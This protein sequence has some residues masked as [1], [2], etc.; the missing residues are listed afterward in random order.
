MIRHLYILWLQG[1][2]KAPDIIQL[3]VRSWQIH[4]PTWTIHL[5][6]WSNLSEYVNLN[7]L[8]PN[9]SS[10][11]E[12][13]SI[14]FT[15]LSDLIRLGILTKFGGLWVDATVFCTKPLDS[16]ILSYIDNGFFA[17]EQD[18][19]SELMIGSWFLYAEPHNYLIN[20]WLESVVKYISNTSQIGLPRIKLTHDEWRAR[21]DTVH[22]FWMHYIFKDLYDADDRFKQIW[23]SV[24]SLKPH[25][26]TKEVHDIPNAL[27]TP[28]NDDIKSRIDSRSEHVYKLWSPNRVKYRYSNQNVLSYLITSIPHHTYVLYAY[29]ETEISKD[30]LEY[31][32]SNIDLTRENTTYCVISNGEISLS[33]SLPP[34]IKLIQR[35]NTGYDFGAWGAALNHYDLPNILKPDDRVIMMNSSLRG[36]ICKTGQI[37][38]IRRLERMIN[39][40]TKLGGISINCFD[41]RNRYHEAYRN[42]NCDGVTKH[43]YIP[44]VQSMMMVTDRIGLQIGVDSNI[45]SGNT[46]SRDSTIEQKELGYSVE[47]LR[48]KYNINAILSKFADLDYRIYQNHTLNARNNNFGDPW[49]EG[50]YFGQTIDPFEAMFIKTA[51]RMCYHHIV[52]IAFTEVGLT[53]QIFILIHNILLAKQKGRKFVLTSDF[54]PDYRRDD[55]MKLSD[56]IDLTT[57]N[58]T[59]EEMDN[60]PL[61]KPL[62]ECDIRYK[63]AIYGTFQNNVEIPNS[64]FP[65][66][67]TDDIN[68]LLGDPTPGLKK[69]VFLTFDIDDFTY[70]KRVSE[71]CG[72]IEENVYGSIMDLQRTK[73]YFKM[74][75]HINKEDFDQI[76]TNLKFN[77]KFYE[78]A[79]SI[80]DLPSDSPLNVVHLRMEE[81]AIDFWSKKNKMTRDDFRHT[82]SNKYITHIRAMIP[83]GQK[84]LIL[85]G[86]SDNL[87]LRNIRE[88]Y[89]ILFIDPTDEIRSAFNTTGRELNAIIDLLAGQRCN[90]VFIGCHSLKLSRGSTFTYVLHHTMKNRLD[91]L[92]D[93]DDI[94]SPPEL[95]IKDLH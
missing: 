33:L 7:K 3:C 46:E 15:A 87:V 40:D 22:Y 1:A 9:I 36:P 38:W 19:D 14:T 81:D 61:V 43:P 75:D 72:K 88:D 39:S 26:R 37:D 85:S 83:K 66:K 95:V 91:I 92:F 11:I 20:K 42:L 29:Y 27:F 5:I 76:L 93:L 68:S 24:R 16:W 31:F 52:S 70:T 18:V 10:R 73:S 82:L 13:K 47:I 86:S 90:N 79:D 48:R 64:I 69:R 45:F 49:W 54:R 62:S 60:C 32:M 89:E 63:N 30:N 53:N 57:L 34:K 21:S 4:N 28:L 74:Y 56:I 77:P 8:V 12:D 51:Y 58:A 78:I 80:L 67:R 50:A 71:Y 55:T 44:H 25:L 17:F 35:E 65:I 84:I 94:G 59:L 2:E 23:D 41:T 6:D